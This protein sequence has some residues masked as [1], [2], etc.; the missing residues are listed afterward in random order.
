MT[1][2]QNLNPEYQN[3]EKTEGKE[4]GSNDREVVLAVEKG[5][6]SFILI[7]IYQVINSTHLN[8]SKHNLLF[9]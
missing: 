5:G 4:R 2:D 6:F 9:E 8:L 1:I 7:I 3:Q